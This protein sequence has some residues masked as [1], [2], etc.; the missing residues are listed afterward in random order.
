MKINRM[1]Y[2]QVISK[3][4]KNRAGSSESN[5]TAKKDSIS[6]SSE[7]I[8]LNEY[9]K[10]RGSSETDKVERIKAELQEGTY[11]VD[12]GKLADKILSRMKAQEN[13]D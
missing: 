13:E 11:K 1:N 10:N 5:V 4:E 9:L 7:S 12:S 3:L 8:K 6:I 2:T